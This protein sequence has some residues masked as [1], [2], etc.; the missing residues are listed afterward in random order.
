MKIWRC[1]GSTALVIA[2]R[3]ELSTGTERQPRNS[4][5]SSRMMRIHTRSQCARK[6]S[7]CGMNT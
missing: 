1:T 6:R 7:S 3:Q 4:K 5:P 2:D